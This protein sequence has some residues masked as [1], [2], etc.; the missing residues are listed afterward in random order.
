MTKKKGT[1]TV[2]VPG[3][4]RELQ[5]PKGLSGD[6]LARHVA[7]VLEIEAA[8]AAVTE[9]KKQEEVSELQRT[10]VELSQMQTLMAEQ[11]KVISELQEQTQSSN[12]STLLALHQRWR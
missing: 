2:R 5:V 12:R 1:M 9:A 10:Q 6:A 4:G 11:A 8:E 3:T 7:S